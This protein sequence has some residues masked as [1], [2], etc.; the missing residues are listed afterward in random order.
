MSY[1]DL[2]PDFRVKIQHNWPAHN[3]IIIAAVVSAIVI[4][5]AISVIVI[6]VFWAVITLR[7]YSGYGIWPI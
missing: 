1:G 6:A 4:A 5:A 2:F 7:R 3:T